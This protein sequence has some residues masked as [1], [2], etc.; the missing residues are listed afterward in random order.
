MTAKGT[1]T[2]VAVASEKFE[3]AVMEMIAASD[4]L[5]RVARA[6]SDGCWAAIEGEADKEGAFFDLAPRKR[7]PC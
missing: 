3:K 5:Y 1:L 2:S 4:E 7:I 6:I